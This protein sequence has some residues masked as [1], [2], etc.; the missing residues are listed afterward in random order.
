MVLLQVV[1]TRAKMYDSADREWAP[2]RD[3]TILDSRNPNDLATSFA[4][5]ERNLES[6]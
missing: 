3:H 4:C 1:K 6:S 5:R 2:F